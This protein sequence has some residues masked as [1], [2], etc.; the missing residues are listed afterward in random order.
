MPTRA[1][2]PVRRLLAAVEGLRRRLRREGTIEPV[3]LGLGVATGLG[4]GVLAWALIELVELVLVTA[5]SVPVPPW[6]LIVVPTVGG[7]VV[8]LLL[9][10]VPEAAGGGVVTT[11]ETVALQGGRF[12]ARVPLVGT[13]AT[14]LALG[15]GASG[16]RE[17]PIVMIGGA[18][19]SLLARLIPVDEDRTRALVAAGAA[20]GIGASFNAP[21]GGMLF[22]IE[23]LLGGLRRAGSLQV[24]VVASV[25]GSV[26]ARQLVGANLAPFR[27]RP[28]LELGSPV[29][30]VL[31]ALLGLTAV[32]VASG[33]RRG[34]DLSRRLFTRLRGKIGRPLSLALS[35]AVVGVVALSLPE[36]LGDGAS[37]PAIDG[38]RRPIQAMLDV[39]FGL[40]WAGA[41]FLLLLLVAKLFTTSVSTGAGAPVGVFAP[42]LFTGA[43][44]GGAY[45]IVAANLLGTE[46]DPG[47]FALVG[48]AAVFSATARA[49]LTGILIVFELTRSYELVLPLMVAVGVATLVAE[50][51]GTDSIYLH[52][53]RQRGVV[54]GQPDDLDV[55]QLVTVGEVMRRDHPVVDAAAPRDEVA[56]VIEASGGHGVAVTGGDG[57]LIGVVTV[58]D[59]AR[60]GATAAE[61]AT[62]RVVTVTPEDPVF[63]AVRRMAALD[64][65]RVP[66][67]DPITRRVVGMMR[68]S[69]VVRAYQRGIDRSLGVQ[70]RRATGQ[71]RDLTGVGFVELFVD[72]TSPLA[73]VAV[74]DVAWPER[75][76]LT[77]VRRHGEVVMPT[78]ATVLE[79]G[80]GLVVLTGAAAEV[81]ALVSGQDPAAR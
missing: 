78:G 18:V 80:D 69:D 52:Q 77:A 22:A 45:G 51:R 75:T 56:A 68:R 25:V 44:L 17:G 70:Q 6:Q 7:L 74:R 3:M 26:T 15:T 57:R 55:L 71:L 64:V 35:G 37:L 76:V 14:G 33:F 23:L 38:T 21:I 29:E 49:P 16:G 36:V 5:W 50:L 59:L 47:A 61:L 27:P 2:V 11:M 54:Y 28:G 13:L 20:A 43:A 39:R 19:G 30:L 53:L 73:G 12:R 79:P 42:T 4:T 9:I 10:R 31:Y 8:G 46:V 48:M 62:R 60:E 63:R 24:V 34:D 58:Q 32:L 65:G 66:V 72:E 1:P 41:A 81:R 67:V 40:D